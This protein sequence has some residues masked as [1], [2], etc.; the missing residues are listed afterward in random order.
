MATGKKEADD[1]NIARPKGLYWYGRPAASSAGQRSLPS[2]ASSSSWPCSLYVPRIP[3]DLLA[4]EFSRLL[5]RTDSHGEPLRFR[6]R[7]A[8]GLRLRPTRA[9]RN[10]RAIAALRS[11]VATRVE[12]PA[13]A[14]PARTPRPASHRTGSAPGPSSLCGAGVLDAWPGTSTPLA[15]GTHRRHEPC[16]ARGQAQAPH[17]ATTP[18]PV[19]ACAAVGFGGGRPARRARRTTAGIAAKSCLRM[20]H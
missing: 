13:Q 2:R 1:Q 18:L 16:C 9:E 10:D 19:A 20:V 17:P 7:A 4:A 15:T 6:D 14:P 11:G 12:G 3:S 8:R 5:L